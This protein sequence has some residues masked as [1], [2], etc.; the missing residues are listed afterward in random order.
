MA[1]KV[2]KKK[3]QFESKSLCIAK[4]IDW[5]N[6]LPF[7]YWIFMLFLKE[8]NAKYRDGLCRN[9]GYDSNQWF[10]EN[11]Y[12]QWIKKKNKCMAEH[13]EIGLAELIKRLLLP[14]NY[15]FGLFP[16]ICDKMSDFVKYAIAFHKVA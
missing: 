8:R 10:A 3:Q 1:H 11:A 15:H 6:K 9:E 12:C 16:V 2:V 7:L 14:I 5:K 4:A 13:I